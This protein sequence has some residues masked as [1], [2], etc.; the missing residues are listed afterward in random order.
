LCFINY[1]DHY[2]ID[3]SLPCYLALLNL[4]SFENHKATTI[5]HA[6]S[7]FFHVTIPCVVHITGPGLFTLHGAYVYHVLVLLMV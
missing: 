5:P 2:L 1:W 7:S 4:G 3:I 6:F